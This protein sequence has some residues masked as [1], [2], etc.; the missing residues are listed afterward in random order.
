MH[1]SDFFLSFRLLTS[2]AC[3]FF[4]ISCFH[5][6]GFWISNRDDERTPNK[7]EVNEKSNRIEI[8]CNKNAWIME[9]VCTHNAVHWV[10]QEILETLLL[11]AV[12]TR[13]ATGL[14]TAKHKM[15][16]FVKVASAFAYFSYTESAQS[17]ANRLLFSHWKCASDEWINEFSRPVPSFMGYIGHFTAE[18]QK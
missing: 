7:N 2:T 9:T 11:L 4:F 8:E 6:I 16:A 14:I 17:R 12:S 1:S 10:Q 15:Y 3:R 5:L 18:W 13:S